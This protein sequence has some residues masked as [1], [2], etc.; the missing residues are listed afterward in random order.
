VVAETGYGQASANGVAT[1]VAR[2]DHT[3]GTPALGATALTAA[4]GNHGHVLTDANITGILPIAQVPTGTTGTTVALGNHNHDTAYVGI[5]GTQDITGAK[6]F[7]TG[8]TRFG[9]ATTT[10]QVTVLGGATNHGVEI[11]RTDGTASTPFIDFHSGATAVDYDVRLLAGG[12]S[13]SSGGGTLNFLTTNL[14]KN[15]VALPIDTAVVH[16]TGSEFVSGNKI[17]MDHLTMKELPN[18]PATP[19]S[20]Y[21]AIYAKSDGL[22]YWL[23]DAGVERQIIPPVSALHQNPGFEGVWANSSTGTPVVVGLCPPNYSYFWCSDGVTAAQET[24]D[25]TEGAYAVAL[26]KPSGTTN[27]RFH[28]TS[29]FPCNPGDTIAFEIDVKSTVNATF[30]TGFL[31]AS[32]Q[33]GCDFFSGDPYLSSVERAHALVGAAA[34]KRVRA[35]WTVPA[36]C[37]WGRFSMTYAPTGGVTGTLRVD[38]SSSTQTVAPGTGGGG[39]GGPEI[40]EEGVPVVNDALGLNFIGGGVTATNDGLGNATVTIPGGIDAQHMRRTNAVAQTIQ[41]ATST[42]YLY[43]TQAESTGGMTYTTGTGAIT[44]AVSG[45]YSISV[46]VGWTA[47]ATGR[48]TVVINRNG[49]SISTSDQAGNAQLATNDQTVTVDLV[50]GDVITVQLYQNSTAP[51]DSSA[52]PDRNYISVT[53]VGGSKGDKGDPGDDSSGQTFRTSLTAAITASNTTPQ[54]LAGLEQTI[55]SPGFF[56]SWIVHADLD[57]QQLGTT[58]VVTGQAKLLVDGVA[59]AGTV[60]ANFLNSA[61]AAS[62]NSRSMNSNTWLL[63]GLAPGTHALSMTWELTGTGSMR[64]NALHSTMTSFR[65]MLSPSATGGDGAAVI[66]YSENTTAQ[67]NISDTALTDDTQVNAVTFVAP[68]SGKVKITASAYLVNTAAAGNLGNVVTGYRWSGGLV[69]NMD[70]NTEAV[71]A[72][73]AQVGGVFSRT[74]IPPEALTPGTSYTLTSQHQVT[75]SAVGYI[76]NKT[77]VVEAV[78]SGPYGV[79]G[80]A[81]TGWQDMAL[82]NSWVPYNAVGGTYEQPGYRR[83]NGVVYLKG[84]VKNGTVAVGTILGNLPVGFRPKAQQVF[85]AVNGSPQSG[86]ATTGTAHTHPMTNWAFRVDVEPDTGNV[87][88][89]S[90]VTG[91]TY[92]SLD[93]ITFPVS[94]FAKMAGS[95]TGEAEEGP[96][97]GWITD[98][99][100]IVAQ[101]NWALNAWN[102]TTKLGNRIRRIGNQVW[103]QLYVNRTAVAITSGTDGNIP[104]TA[105]V[106]LPTGYLP[107]GNV[108][109]PFR[110]SGNGGMG[111]I[112]LAGMVYIDTWW[113]STPINVGNNILANVTY[114]LD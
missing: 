26:T 108:E 114:R 81:D 19:S 50:A 36:G 10:Q 27:C 77:L 57:V 95:A 21:N 63:T 58:Q 76:A 53:L 86:A 62:T 89:M 52:N 1:S 35:S 97:T 45:R 31:S 65:T 61:S 92:L 32:T 4:A 110:S 64:C 41:H 38:N 18:T 22:P 33:A 105:V 5:A 111:N 70:T 23:D 54:N 74:F 83:I 30:N 43:A 113:P 15:G 87:V 8:T 109:V 42:N 75:S 7:S 44:I 99:P 49:N 72:N 102:D 12:G 103:L 93:N 104:D 34:Y 100:G 67:S 17:L 59:Q 24:V 55:S 9:S 98:P 106:Q 96:D 69:R 79:H 107:S 68:P 66:G 3:H 60:V 101:T 16:S 112:N 25:K 78:G 82:Q 40:Y 80:A 29:V 91:N 47:N 88:L 39:G 51:L 56:A 73:R 6:T 46:G 90:V 71:T 94:D 48:R 11:G 14:Q 20:G 84:L 13:G 2:S 28:S 85:A 37:Y